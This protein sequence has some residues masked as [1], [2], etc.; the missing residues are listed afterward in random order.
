ML[1]HAQALQHVLQALAH[2][3]DAIAVDQLVLQQM[4][5]ETFVGVCKVEDEF[6][7]GADLLFAELR[8]A[9][10]ERLAQTS[11]DSGGKRES[12]V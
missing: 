3:L 7:I 12:A 1:E 6:A 5:E 9:V 8:T 11:V 10:G 4:M 2:Q